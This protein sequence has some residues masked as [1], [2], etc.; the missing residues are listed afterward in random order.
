MEETKVV[1]RVCQELAIAK[2]ITIVAINAQLL[3]KKIQN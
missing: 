3:K 1:A 2:A